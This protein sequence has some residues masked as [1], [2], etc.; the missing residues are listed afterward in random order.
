[1]RSQC[2][3][4][5]CALKNRHDN[6][7]ICSPRKLNTKNVIMTNNDTNFFFF[8]RHIL[9]ISINFIKIMMLL[10]GIYILLDNNQPT[11]YT[12]YKY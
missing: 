10:F 4:L 7:Q 6:T 2:M 3:Y 5:G 8:T 1:M 12:S 9:Y 11:P